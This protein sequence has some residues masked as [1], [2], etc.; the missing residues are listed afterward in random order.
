MVYWH[1]VYV[2]FEVNI[3]YS[4]K[5]E[6][7]LPKFSLIVSDHAPYP[8]NAFHST[9]SHFKAS[10]VIIANFE[11]RKIQYKISCSG[12]SRIC[13]RWAPTPKVGV[14]TYHFAIFVLKAA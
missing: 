3:F 1:I 2:S 7:G 8:E 5:D 9:H 12:G 6:D 4:S 10:K 14:V 13:L 11:M